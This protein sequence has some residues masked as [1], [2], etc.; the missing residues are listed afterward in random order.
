[1]MKSRSS[2][3]KLKEN[4]LEYKDR[5]IIVSKPYFEDDSI[6]IEAFEIF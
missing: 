4:S 2:I 5:R 6:T 1:M 3:K